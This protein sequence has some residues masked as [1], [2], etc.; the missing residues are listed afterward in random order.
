[1]ANVAGALGLLAPGRAFE[2]MR[3]ET[4][5]ISTNKMRYTILVDLVCGRGAATGIGWKS[6]CWPENIGD[7]DEKGKGNVF[8]GKS[9]A[10]KLP[11]LDDFFRKEWQSG[12]G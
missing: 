9:G 8:A 11:G 10:E 4:I 2:F 7:C 1:M 5:V 6:C 12:G 3:L